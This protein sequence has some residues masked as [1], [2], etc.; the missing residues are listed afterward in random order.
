MCIE[1]FF[2]FHNLKWHCVN[3]KKLK[4]N[5]LLTTKMT[6]NEYKTVSHFNSS[7]TY[8]FV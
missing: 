4:I 5:Y 8:I 1:H 7:A 3:G 2:Y 6:M